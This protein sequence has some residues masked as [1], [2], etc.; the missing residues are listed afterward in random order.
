VQ[1]DVDE[2]SAWAETPCHVACDGSEV[3]YIGMEEHLNR[4]RHRLIPHRQKAG[5]RPDDGHQSPTC[6]P[7]LISRDVEPNRAVARVRDGSSV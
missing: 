6:E 3:F 1:A 5:V 4:Y 2:A 7:E